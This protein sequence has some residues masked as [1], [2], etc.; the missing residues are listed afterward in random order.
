MQL[1]TLRPQTC[2]HL[3]GLTHCPLTHLPHY[4]THLPQHPTCYLA[5]TTHLTGVTLQLQRPPH[6]GHLAVITLRGMAG[7]KGGRPT[8]APLT[9]MGWWGEPAVPRP[10]PY[11]PPHLF[12]VVTGCYFN[13]TFITRLTGP[14]TGGGREGR[15]GRPR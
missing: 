6:R 15:E 7:G 2:P 4:P 9:M 13:I 11:S 14:G 5:T 8:P 3:P 1:L 12:Y 10:A